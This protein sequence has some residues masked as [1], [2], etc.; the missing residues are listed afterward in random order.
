MPIFLP[1]FLKNSFH[2]ISPH[3]VTFYLMDIMYLLGEAKLF[4]QIQH[5]IVS[6][7]EKGSERETTD[8]LTHS[9]MWVLLQDRFCFY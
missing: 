8:R 4:L 9:A 7:I 5:S 3:F 2:F 6:Y 1:A